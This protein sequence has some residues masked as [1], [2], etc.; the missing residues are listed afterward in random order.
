MAVIRAALK[1]VLAHNYAIG[2]R[3]ETLVAVCFP[4]LVD[5]PNGF[6]ESLDEPNLFPCSA[7][8]STASNAPRT[9][10]KSGQG[11]TQCSIWKLSIGADGRHAK[12]EG[13]CVDEPLSGGGFLVTLEKGAQGWL[14]LKSGSTWIG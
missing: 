6:L 2:K 4:T 11:A 3:P 5:P 14:V 9:L 8:K 10:R 13:S 1:D 12:V 7:L